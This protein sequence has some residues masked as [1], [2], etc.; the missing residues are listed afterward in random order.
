MR[1][2]TRQALRSVMVAVAFAASS[3][4]GYLASVAAF[5]HAVHGPAA[6]HAHHHLHVHHHDHT[7]DLV[8]VGVCTPE[9]CDENGSAEPA[10][11]QMHVHCCSAT[12]AVPAGDCGLRLAVAPGAIAPDAGPSV[13]LGLLSYPPLRP[14]SATA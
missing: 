3:L 4:N 5:E 10:C 8:E 6:A 14:P 1:R 7:A 11:T 12:P 13:P 9:G 2:M